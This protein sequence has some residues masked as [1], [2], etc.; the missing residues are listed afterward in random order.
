M[1]VM[2][3]CSLRIVSAA[4]QLRHA[5]LPLSLSARMHAL[6]DAAAAITI[7]YCSVQK[8]KERTVERGSEQ[9]QRIA[10]DGLVET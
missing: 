3:A 5:L 4:L 9:L 2:P 1:D 8:D 7:F 10:D 6:E